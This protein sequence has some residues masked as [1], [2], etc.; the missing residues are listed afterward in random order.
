[1]EVK[2]ISRLKNNQNFLKK[3]F[4]PAEIRYCF[5]KKNCSQHL[6]VRFAAKEAVWKCLPEKI[7]LSEIEVRSAPGGEPKIYL[8]GKLSRKV[9][10]SLSHTKTFAVAVAVYE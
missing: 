2:R 8:S 10:V 5:S 4:S 1:M 3:I 6:A 9:S 7:S